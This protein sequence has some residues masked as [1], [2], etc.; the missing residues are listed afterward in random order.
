MSLV[1]VLPDAQDGLLAMEKDLDSEIVDGWF[2]ALDGAS[3][4][5]VALPKITLDWK[6]DI[7]ASSWRRCLRSPTA[8]TSRT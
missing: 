5:R 7:L 4:S 2:A 8:V 1:I 6:K 3:D